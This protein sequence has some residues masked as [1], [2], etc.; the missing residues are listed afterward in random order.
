MT[1]RQERQEADEENRIDRRKI[2]PDSERIIAEA[3]HHEDFER[4]ATEY[5]KILTGDAVADW[6]PW[7]E[8]EG[9][10]S[11]ADSVAEQHGDKTVIVEVSVGE[12]TTT[13]FVRDG[14]GTYRVR[15]LHDGDYALDAVVTEAR[16]RDE[17][18]LEPTTYDVEDY[19]LELE[20][21][22]VTVDSK[23]SEIGEGVEA[24]AVT[25]TELTLTEATDD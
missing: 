22:A 10:A 24:P 12:E 14:A 21:T 7:R 4:A 19:D 5:F 25:I 6:E 1:T 11:L 9:A 18:E 23:S 2:S 17:D 15:E 8:V 13:A 3:I 20:E 16:D